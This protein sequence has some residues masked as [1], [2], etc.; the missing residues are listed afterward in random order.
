[1]A[2]ALRA[3]EYPDDELNV[4][5]T[6]RGPFFAVGDDVL[7]ELAATVG[8]CNPLRPFDFS[9]AAE[10]LGEVGKAL[11]ILKELHLKRNWRPIAD[12]LADFLERTR[13]HAGIAI[14]PTGEQALANIMRV[15]DEARRFEARGATSFRNFVEWFD[16]Q[17]ERREAAEAPIV[18]EGT[19][20]VRIMT[21]HK[22]KGLEFPIVILCDPGCSRT[23]SRPSR[24]VDAALGLW[25]APLAGCVPA[26][27]R[28]HEE[29]VLRADDAEE[30]RIAYVAAT[31]ARDLLVVPATGEE[32]VAGWVD[33]LHRAIYPPAIAKRRPRRA[34]GCPSFGNDSVLVRPDRAPRGADDAV[35][36]GLHQVGINQVVWWDP[37]LLDLSTRTIGGIRHQDLLIADDVG[38]DEQGGLD[39]YEA[40]ARQRRADIAVAGRPSIIAESVTAMAVRGELTAARPVAI[41]KTGAN[42][43][44]RPVGARFG[45]LVHAVLAEIDYGADG[46]AIAV[47]TRLWARM[48][49][50]SAAE[51]SAAVE[52]VRVALAHPLMKRAAAA[53]ARGDCRREVPLFSRLDDGTIVDGI[54][55]LAFREGSGADV[56]WV[57][58]DYKTDPDVAGHAEYNDQVDFYARAVAAA[59]GAAATGILF[60]V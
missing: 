16:R 24:Y 1:M 30:I 46:A 39:A 18:E 47:M 37:A 20:G 11:E 7:L 29:D 45:T 59:T 8:G 52:A 6:L 12:T 53:E 14:W 55:D 9:S 48:V 42:G 54:A 56:C 34:P 5:A 41:E 38:P 26:E 57:V 49:G 17:G 3:I 27:L 60:A 23:H 13:A 15:L 58:V 36:P 32:R 33:V 10:S 43:S 40:W 19:D 2:A 44:A 22:A 21:V 28:D 50:A 25:A 31:R 51:Q 4:Y 35:A